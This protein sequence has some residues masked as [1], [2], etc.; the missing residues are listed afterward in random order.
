MQEKE[1]EGPSPFSSPY[2]SCSWDA[3]PFVHQ[4]LDPQGFRRCARAILNNFKY[5]LEGVPGAL[6]T[7]VCGGVTLAL[8]H[9]HVVEI[10]ILQI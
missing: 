5:I 1:G 10:A 9:T 4:L 3:I 7:T 8:G 6:F 2:A